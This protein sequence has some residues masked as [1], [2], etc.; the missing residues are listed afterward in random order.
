MT[1]L[2][3]FYHNAPRLTCFTIS[4]KFAEI[5]KSQLT[6]YTYIPKTKTVAMKVTNLSASI[7]ALYDRS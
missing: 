4:P 2:I 6:C 5:L 1:I 3:E 7:A